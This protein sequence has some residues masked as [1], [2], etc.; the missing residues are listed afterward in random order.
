MG[1]AGIALN[2]PRGKSPCAAQRNLGMKARRVNS[3]ILKKI[4]ID[5]TDDWDHSIDTNPTGSPRPPLPS[6]V[7]AKPSGSRSRD[8]AAN[9]SLSPWF[10]CFSIALSEQ[11]RRLANAD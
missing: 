7:H 10:R 2:S 3:E 11:P 8:Q 6:Q 4:H 9:F 5:T 1:Q